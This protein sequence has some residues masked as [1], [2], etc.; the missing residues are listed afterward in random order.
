MVLPLAAALGRINPAVEEAGRTLGASRLAGVLPGH[1]AAERAGPRG[2]LDAGVLADRQ[3]VRGAGAARRQFR[4]DARHAGRGADHVG[5]RLAVRRCHRHGADRHRAGDQP[6]SMSGW[7]SGAS[8]HRG[9]RADERTRLRARPGGGAALCG[10]RTGGGVPAGA[11][12]GAGADL[13]LRHRRSSPGRRSG[14]TLHWYC[15][16]P[17]RGGI[18]QFVPFQPG[19]RRPRRQWARCCS[20]RQRRSGWRGIGF[21]AARWCKGCC[22]RR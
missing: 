5:V 8:Q 4:E 10:G 11:A 7:S 20:A 12:G 22:C 19:A 16:D 15:E 21:P 1:L 2:R 18:Y 9:R 3:L 6:G 14:F 17:R 13:V